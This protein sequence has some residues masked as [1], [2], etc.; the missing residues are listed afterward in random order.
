MSD[1]TA[2]LHAGT[3][4][5]VECG[6]QAVAFWPVVDPDI[7]SSPYCRACLDKAKTELFCKLYGQRL[8]RDEEERE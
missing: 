6:A 4:K 8:G 1:S 5:C 7:P 3:Q 2:M